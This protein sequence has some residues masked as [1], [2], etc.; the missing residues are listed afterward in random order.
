VFG[1]RPDRFDHEIEFVGAVDLARYAVGHV[2]PDE[3]GFGEVIEPVNTLRVKVQQQEHRARRVL[4]PR[5]QEQMIG[6]E[7]KH[8]RNQKRRD[9]Q[10][11]LRPIGSAV[12]GLTRRTPPFGVSHRAAHDRGRKELFFRRIR[13]PAGL[14]QA[15]AGQQ[16]DFR[17]LDQSI[18]NR[19]R[20][21]RIEKD[22]AP[23]GERRVC[24]DNG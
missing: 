5:E 15:V 10:E 24:G 9:S 23:V 13:A 14:A 7:V 22:V 6:A 2:G 11:T 18:G 21:G 17:V 1:V 3:Q 12:E 8:G 20:N 4:R 19:R 16:E